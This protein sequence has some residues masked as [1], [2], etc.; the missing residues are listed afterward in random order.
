[1]SITPGHLEI[2]EGRPA[3]RILGKGKKP[4][5]RPVLSA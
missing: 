5:R 3:F 1:L 2:F 4:R